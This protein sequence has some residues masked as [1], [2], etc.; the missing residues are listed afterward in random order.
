MSLYYALGAALRARMPTVL[1]NHH[2]CF[3]V[4]DATGVKQCW[5][6]RE[7][8]FDV[9]PFLICCKFRLDSHSSY[10]LGRSLEV[11]VHTGHPEH[12]TGW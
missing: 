8:Q 12:R 5:V 2:E 9:S 7:D 3:Y 10:A 4:F 11:L 6:S 1:C